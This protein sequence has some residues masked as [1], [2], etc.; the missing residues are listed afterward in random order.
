M[1]LTCNPGGI[2]HAWV[3][4]LFI[5]REYNE[6]EDRRDYTFIAAT[7]DDNPQLLEASP[8]YKQM[9]DLL[10][11]DV[12]RAWRY[13]DWNALAGTFFNEFRPETHVIEPFVRV[14]DEW[15]KYRAFDYGLDCFA[16]L[17]IAVDFDGRCYVYREIQQSGLIVSEAAKLAVECTPP[18][19]HI[20]FTIA[21]PDMWNRQKDSGK[22]MAEIFAQNGVGLLR[23]SNNRIQG[24]MAVKEMLKPMKS[25]TDRP[26]LLV[27]RD[28]RGL[29]RNIQ[30][31]QHD[32]K[33]PSDCATQP[34]DITHICDA[35]RY[36][37][38][39][40]VLQSERAADDEEYIHDDLTEYDDEMT[41]GD[42]D[43]SYIDYGG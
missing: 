8:E 41:G 13:G 38:I 37:A 23:A 39:T 15:R 12:R 35:A 20:E 22:S 29:I 16:C 17:W 14:P 25:E 2:G 1:Y 30:L 7:V 42:F 11:E 5:D 26:G 40:R 10:P 18:N 4:R 3:K 6:G 43:D 34:H 24:W 32:E 27:T 31:I 36:F 21:P 9:L 19:E 28:C 33:N